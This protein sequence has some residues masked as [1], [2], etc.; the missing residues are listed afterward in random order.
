MKRHIQ[1]IKTGGYTLVEMI[2]YI[3]LFCI[4]TIAVI[5]SLITMTRSFRET[6]VQADL[7]QSS[8][9]IERISRETRQA[10][11]VNSISSSDLKLDTTDDAGVNKTV[12]FV[13]SGT[14]VQFYENDILTGNL[15]T[16]NIQVTALSFTQITTTK[17]KAIK[18][19]LSVKSTRDSLS[20]VET[21]YD[22]VSL[23]GS[24]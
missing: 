2:F 13:L 20:R 1:K 8:G 15:N 19:T 23:R 9:I 3:A 5:N 17:G 14:D 12:R 10:Y 4:L 16:T 18:M 22:T 11:G 21:Y 6:S 24:Y 7:V